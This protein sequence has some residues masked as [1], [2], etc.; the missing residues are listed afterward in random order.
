ME[1]FLGS[2]R[3][4]LGELV[5]FCFTVRYVMRDDVEGVSRCLLSHMILR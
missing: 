5:F 4:V 1:T 3:I 2:S